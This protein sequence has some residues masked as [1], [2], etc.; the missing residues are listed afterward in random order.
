MQDKTQ[1]S[2][3]H[4]MP[5]NNNSIYNFQSL[6]LFSEKVRSEKIIKIVCTVQ[7]N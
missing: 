4:L 7:F 5:I 6:L 2:K 1:N 3:N